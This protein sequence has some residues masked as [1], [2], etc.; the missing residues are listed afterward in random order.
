MF[1]VLASSL[2]WGS[3]H[4]WYIPILGSTGMWH[5]ASVVLT[6]IIF[7]IAFARTR[8]IL[9]VIAVHA[10]INIPLPLSFLYPGPVLRMLVFAV[11]LSGFAATIILASWYMIRQLR[12]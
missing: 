9:P 6:G 3:L 4:L 12:H 8:N 1:S 7:G 11:L 2:M 5:H 10:Y